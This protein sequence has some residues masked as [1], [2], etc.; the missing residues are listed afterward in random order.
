MRPIKFRGITAST[1]HR[2][3]E[4]S[5]MDLNAPNQKYHIL[6]E[7]NNWYE[8]LPETVGQFT[9]LSDMNGKELWEGDRIRI[10]SGYAG[11]YQTKPFEANI[12]YN[13]KE[14]RFCVDT[15]ESYFLPDGYWNHVATVIGT[16]HDHLMKGG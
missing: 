4:G 6:D 10:G 15:N 5:L 16:I 1:P 2:W 11:D 7:L 9:G 3:V 8:V 14:G 13:E 12:I